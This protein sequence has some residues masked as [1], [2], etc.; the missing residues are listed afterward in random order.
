[1]EDLLGMIQ[2]KQPEGLTAMGEALHM[3]LNSFD[4]DSDNYRNI[5]LFTNGMQNLPPLVD[6]PDDPANPSCTLDSYVLDGYGIPIYTLGTG[7]TTSSTWGEL[8]KKI[9][10]QTG[11]KSWYTTDPTFN[12][13]V[14]FIT[15]LVDMHRENS[16][17]IVGINSGV[18]A[19]GQGP[20]T[21]TFQ[22]NK[23]TKSGIFFVTWHTLNPVTTKALKME[24]FGPGSATP[25]TPGTSHHGNHHH[26]GGISFPL[27]G[28]KPHEGTW[29][30]KISGNNMSGEKVYYHAGVIVDETKMHHYVAAE[31]MDYGTGDPIVLTA[32]LKLDRQGLANA[33]TVQCT[34]TRPRNALGTFLNRRD[35][36][37]PF[38]QDPAALA[39]SDD[40][41]PNLYTWKLHQLIEKQGLGNL[42]EPITDPLPVTLRH[43]GNGKYQAHYTNTKL[44]G[45]Y[46]FDFF[47]KGN[48]PLIGNY[49]RRESSTAMVRVKTADPGKSEIYCEPMPGG[50]KRVTVVPADKFE[51][52]LG[53]GYEKNVGITSSPGTVSP[54]KDERVNGTYTAV[55]SGLPPDSDPKL[56]VKVNGRALKENFPCGEMFTQKWILGAY[57]G[58]D[59]PHSW[60][61]TLYN[62][63]L[64][65]GAGL[66]FYFAPR[67]GISG[68]A[69]CNKFKVDPDLVDFVDPLK[70][71][72]LSG[73]LKFYPVIG[74]FQLALFGGG[75]YYI[76]N[77]GDDKFGINFGSSAEVRLTAGFSIEAKYNYHSIF[78]TGDNL[79]FST[80][81][82][83]VRIRF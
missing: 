18:F 5:V 52:F 27:S 67:W 74:T 6:C 25:L 58:R 75:G 19:K 1:M 62:P 29:T 61:N 23:A 43:I 4:D 72:N 47:I 49:E 41:F 24:V 9:A 45:Q 64:S 31:P 53:P 81:L 21:H 32:S 50:K 37:A 71:Y 78:T 66:E 8:L 13:A 57:I 7:V 51:N 65:L 48:H 33:D 82:G 44:P 56:T 46:K 76:V 14:D 38:P 15:A 69:G 54:V 11:G 12:L 39:Q 63:G 28:G 77:P 73:N 10:D 79:T 55:V 16:P 80:F 83:G 30:I 42:L 2:S 59:L 70:I 34:V 26:I 3:A 36:Q 17:A 40:R 22:V 20:V 35:P 68:F 60:L